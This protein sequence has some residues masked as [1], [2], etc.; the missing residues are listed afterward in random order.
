MFA[1]ESIL[2]ATTPVCKRNLL[3]NNQKLD[4]TFLEMEDIPSKGLLFIGPKAIGKTYLAQNLA[5]NLNMPLVCISIDK[6]VFK[7]V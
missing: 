2:T 5:T 7:Q 4:F 6:L 1:S 3:N